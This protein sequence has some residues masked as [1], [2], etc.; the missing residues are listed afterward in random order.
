MMHSSRADTAS[1]F[2]EA[3]DDYRVLLRIKGAGAGAE[4]GL[5]IGI[6]GGGEPE[7]QAGVEELSGSEEVSFASPE[8]SSTYDE[9]RVLEVNLWH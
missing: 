6:G 8:L 9:G 3:A 2:P 1:E 5:V 4:A 7:P